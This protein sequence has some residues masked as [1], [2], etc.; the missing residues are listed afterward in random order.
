MS[1]QVKN[2]YQFLSKTHHFVGS[3]PFCKWPECEAEIPP[4][5]AESKNVWSF[6]SAGT[7]VQD[8]FIVLN[9]LPTD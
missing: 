2:L 9:D 3:F 6:M 4:P 5:R 8:Y 1:G 7:Y